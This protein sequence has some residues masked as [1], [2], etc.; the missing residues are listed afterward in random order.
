MELH[1]LVV[2]CL[3]GVLVLLSLMCYHVQRSRA[4]QRHSEKIK[5]FKNALQ[6]HNAQITYRKTQLQRYDFLRYNLD[7]AL[8]PQIQIKL[9]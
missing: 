5:I 3:A 1:R 4:K 9:Y 2:L 8:Q 6:A 7:D